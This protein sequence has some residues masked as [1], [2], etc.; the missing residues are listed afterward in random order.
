MLYIFAIV[1]ISSTFAGRGGKGH[2]GGK[3]SGKGSGCASE[4]SDAEQDSYL[5]TIMAPF[6]SDSADSTTCT[7]VVMNSA[8][9]HVGE[10]V[11][12]TR[13]LLSGRP[14]AISFDVVGSTVSALQVSGDC[15]TTA[16]FTVKEVTFNYAE[17][18][19]ESSMEV[20]AEEEAT[21]DTDD[22]L[23]DLRRELG[24]GSSDS[25]DSSEDSSDSSE[26]SNGAYAV[27]VLTQTNSD[28]GVSF[29]FTAECR[30]AYTKDDAD[31]CT[32]S[33]MMCRHG[34][35]TYYV[36]EE[37]SEPQAVNSEFG[38]YCSAVDSDPICPL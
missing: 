30:V 28:D 24:R 21:E 20:V 11:G 18:V 15:L 10:A 8:W 29:D 36:V 26:E 31:V 1:L 27:L 17:V 32:P 5:N 2:G 3:G 38:L 22:D 6:T 33:A 14:E 34:S 37:D 9:P 4:L 35:Y 12:A 19:E 7:M 16:S 25:S 23:V 13:R